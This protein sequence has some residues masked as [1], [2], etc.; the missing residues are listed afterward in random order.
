MKKIW[1]ALLVG[2]LIISIGS[3]VLQYIG[4]VQTYN[5]EAVKYKDTLDNSIK[6]FDQIQQTPNTHLRSSLAYQVWYSPNNIAIE[7]GFLNLM[8]TRSSTT[9]INPLERV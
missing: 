3:N 1:G 6:I 5:I 7:G 2:V 8:A 9:Q 4:R